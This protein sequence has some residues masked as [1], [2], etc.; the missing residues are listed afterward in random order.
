MRCSV[1]FP[2][3]ELVGTL[4]MSRREFHESSVA[5][6]DD[7]RFERRPYTATALPEVGQVCIRRERKIRIHRKPLPYKVE[8]CCECVT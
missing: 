7:D 8:Q 5:M 6:S 3:P 4:L 2:T 1:S